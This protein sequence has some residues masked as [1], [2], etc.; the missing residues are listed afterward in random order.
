MQLKLISYLSVKILLK[1]LYCN[2]LWLDHDFRRKLRSVNPLINI[3]LA[4]MRKTWKENEVIIMFKSK[5]N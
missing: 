2:F 5:H 4:G 1:L 3:S